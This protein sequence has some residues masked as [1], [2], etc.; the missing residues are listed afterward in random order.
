M[1]EGAPNRLQR[2]MKLQLCDILL[3]ISFD[4]SKSVLQILVF[5]M[6]T[7][8]QR[9]HRATEIF[10]L[11]GKHTAHQIAQVVR[12]IRVV[13][14]DQIIVAEIRILPKNAFAQHEITKRV[15][16]DFFFHF[17]RRNRVA[18]TFRH[19]LPFDIPKAVDV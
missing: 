19:L 17:Q 10:V 1:V 13:T 6:P 12:Q 18:E 7:R 14:S 9:L 5:L 16:A 8:A 3:H 15:H 11:H 2:P 4:L